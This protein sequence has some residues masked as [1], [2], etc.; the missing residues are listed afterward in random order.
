[1]FV[2]HK[3]KK[4]FGIAPLMLKFTKLLEVNSNAGF[5]LMCKP[6]HSVVVDTIHPFKID[7]TPMSHTYKEFCSLHMLWMCIWNHHTDVQVSQAFGSA[8]YYGYILRG[9]PHHSVVVE[10]I[11]PFKI[12]LTPMSHTYKA[13][14]NLHMLWMCIWNHHTDAQVSQAFGSCLI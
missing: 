7:L 5:I 8:S 11:H 1:V 9:K 6:H 4:S 10:A 3:H 14:Y 12:A 13:L 2:Q